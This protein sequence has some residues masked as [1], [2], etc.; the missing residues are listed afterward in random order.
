MKFAVAALCVIVICGCRIIDPAEEIPSY[1]QVNTVSLTTTASEGSNSHA[2]TDAWIYIDGE[3]IGG[4]EIPCKVPVLEEGGHTILILPGV[5]Q[6]GLS[7][8]R[9]I[10]PFYKGWESSINLTRGEISTVSPVFTYFPGISFDWICD[11]SNV[12]INFN[13]TGHT[14]F[15]GVYSIQT[16][17][18]AF[19]GSSARIQ[20]TETE[21]Y[22]LGT[23]SDSFILDQGR[24]IYL[25]CNYKCDQPFTVGLRNCDVPN[26]SIIPWL[27][28][29]PSG[30]WNKIY[31]RLNDALIGF[32]AG[33]HY[34]ISFQMSNPSGVNNSTFW[35]DNL[36][37]IN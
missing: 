13:G 8:T 14:P 17:S 3:L 12:G 10:Y 36:K 26:G 32:P 29:A 27:V 37:L 23:S 4:F 22:F 20:L 28:I 6:N 33:A 15:P 5:K 7:S 31:I 25:E 16:S 11:F 18:E 1:V 34:S 2:I 30:E 9:A 24:E 19:E 21:N 35:L